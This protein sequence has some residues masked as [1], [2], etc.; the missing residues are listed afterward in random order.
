MDIKKLTSTILLSTIGISLFSQK[1]DN[2]D[3]FII[4]QINEKRIVG[5][6]L[7]IIKNRKIVKTENYG[8]ANLQDSIPVDKN[9]IFT[10]NSITK[11]FTGVAIM[12]L[13]ENGKIDLNSAISTY[14][15]SLPDAWRNIT[16][17]QLASHISGIPN[18]MDADANLISE[19]AETSWQ[20]VQ[21]LPNEFKPGEQFSYN[22]T[23]YLLLGKVIEKVSGMPFEDFILE[24]QF[25]A[26]NMENTI[27]AGFRD[28]YDVINH[29]ARGYNYFRNGVISN[30]NPEVFPKFLRTA[31][32]MQSTATELANWIIALQ[33]LTLVKKNE[34]LAE[35]WKPSLLNNGKTV[36]FGDILNGYAIGWFAVTRPDHPAVAS[37]GG[38]RSAI[39]IYPKENVTVIVLTNLQGASPENFIDQIAE[40]Y[41]EHDK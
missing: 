23:N 40:Y 33:S 30:I 17:R 41:F 9:T 14:L 4:K 27:N 1:E 35:L 24:F 26:A 3:N 19:N 22:Q 7:A 21:T 15:D 39:F 5:L 8:F 16:L 10:I 31:A 6:Q 12:Q 20:K 11:A 13:V 18:I 29:S 37:V 38:G 28:Y 2:V 36:G 32:G 34:T 25:K